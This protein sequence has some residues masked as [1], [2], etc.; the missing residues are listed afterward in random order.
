MADVFDR[1]IAALTAQQAG[2]TAAL[3][4]HVHDID[5]HLTSVDDEVLGLKSEDTSEKSRLD[6]IE[7]GISRIADAL[8]P[9][10]PAS[11][12]DSTA[13]NPGGGSDT[14]AVSGTGSDAGN[15]GGAPAPG[16]QDGIGDSAGNPGG[17]GSGTGTQGDAS[18]SSDASGSGTTDQGPTPS[19]GPGM[20]THGQVDTPVTQP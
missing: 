11:G 14:G 10:A 19:S 9:A 17:D 15:P 12:G 3:Q 4:Q 2:D 18:G 16:A 8:A 13:A 20:E 5:A 1:I 6:A 7:A